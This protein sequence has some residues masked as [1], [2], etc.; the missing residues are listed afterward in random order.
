MLDAECQARLLEWLDAGDARRQVVS[1]SSDPL[2]AR[3]ERGLF[4]EDLYY[5]LN[6]VMVQL[7]ATCH[8][9]AKDTN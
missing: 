4:S 6:T 2:F 8:P 1:L 3:V 7:D 5:R 9:V